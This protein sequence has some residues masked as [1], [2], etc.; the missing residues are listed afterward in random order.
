MRPAGLELIG[1]RRAQT[2]C[3][4]Y[5]P[6][7]PAVLPIPVTWDQMKV[8]LLHGASREDETRVGPG[9][10]GVSHQ[11]EQSVG[12]RQQGGQARARTDEPTDNGG[13]L[14]LT[15]AQPAERDIYLPRYSGSSVRSVGV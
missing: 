11:P 10:P 8:W 4:G 13:G 14:A 3:T 12:A 6:A 5:Y 2:Y 1:E 7:A 15:F 9:G